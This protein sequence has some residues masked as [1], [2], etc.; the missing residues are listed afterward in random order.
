MNFG[1]DIT[2]NVVLTDRLSFLYSI[3]PLTVKLLLFKYED[4]QLVD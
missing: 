3:P 4:G 2:L 1:T